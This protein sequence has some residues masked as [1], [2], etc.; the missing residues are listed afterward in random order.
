[1]VRATKTIAFN[2]NDVTG[3]TGS[4]TTVQISLSVSPSQGTLGTDWFFVNYNWDS[5]TTLSDKLEAFKNAHPSNQP[6][7]E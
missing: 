4:D 5:S 3:G 2:E 7:S 1:M 6:D